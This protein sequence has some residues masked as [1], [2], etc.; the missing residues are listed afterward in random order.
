VAGEPPCRKGRWGAGSSSINSSQ[1]HALATKWANCTLG[2]IKPSLTS[3]TKEVIVPLYLALVQPHRECCAQF[4]AP[5]CKRD[6][7]VPERFQRRATK[8]VQGLEGMSYKERLRTSGLSSLEK[9][10]LKGSLIALCSFLSRGCG[11]GGAEL[12]SLRSSDRTHGNGSQ[13]RQGSLRLDMRKRTMP[14]TTCF[15]FWSALKCS[16]GWTRS[17]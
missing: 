8:L 3:Q 1:Q 2:C 6:V 17:L 16:G 10:R 14:L 5:R 11:E 7:E 9:R 12:S 13:L 4:W 15:S